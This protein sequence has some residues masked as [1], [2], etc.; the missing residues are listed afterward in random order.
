M[1]KV[2][3]KRGAALLLSGLMVFSIPWVSVNAQGSTEESTGTYEIAAPEEQGDSTSTLNGQTSV[4]G[5]GL[6]EE[7]QAPEG[8]NSTEQTTVF[9]LAVSRQANVAARSG[10]CGTN[11]TWRMD[12][13][14]LYISGSGAMDDYTYGEQGP[15]EEIKDEITSVIVGEGVTAVGAYAFVECPNLTEVSLAS[16]VKELKYAAFGGCSN[17]TTF[18]ATGLQSIGDYVFQ[19]AALEHFTVPASL[20]NISTLASMRAE[21]KEF[22][23]EQGNAVYTAKDGILYTDGGATLFAYPAEKEGENFQ[24]PDGVRTIG[25]G[26]FLYARNLRTIEFPDTVQKFGESAFQ[27]SRLTSVEIP[28]SVTE[29]GDFTFYS[30]LYLDRVRFGSGLKKTSYQMFRECFSL[31][32]VTFDP[33]LQAL[34]AHTFAYCHNLV[35]IELPAYIIEIGSGAFGNCDKLESFTSHGLQIIPYQAFLGCTSLKNVN[36]NE[37]VT[38]I[39][40]VSFIGCDA[41]EQVTMP[42]SVTFVDENAFPTTTEITC[43][44]T[45]MRKFGY[46]GYRYLDD[47]TVSGTERYD[48]AYQVLRLVNEQRQANGLNPLYMDESLLNSAMVRA[49][50]TVILFAH[51]RPD[52]A[53]CFSINDQMTAENIAYGQGS[54]SS[55]MNSWMN[56]DGHRANILS[57]TATS[58][59]IGCF[60]YG[61]RTY[62]VQC[63]GQNNISQNAVQPS[64]RQRTRTVSIAAETFSEAIN[65]YGVIWG[66]LE[67]Y[68]YQFVTRVSGRSDTDIELNRGA[69]AQLYLALVNPGNDASIQVDGDFSWSSS[70]AR[71]VSVTNAGS[72]TA[73][74]AG[75]ASV[76]AATKYYTG[77]PVR[78]SV[79]SE[80]KNL[81]SNG[82]YV[83]KADGTGVTMGM[84][85]SGVA[86]E[87]IEYRWV[88]CDE[89]DQQWFTVQDWT[90]GNEW[91]NWKPPVAGNY[92]Y[93]CYARVAGEETPVVEASIGVPYHVI[94]GVCQMP[95][96]GTGGGFLIGL[97]TYDNPNQSYRYEM[98]IL[99]CTL[100]AQGLPAWTYTTG[101]CV[102]PDNCLWT[103]WQPKYGYYWT[104]FRVY[105]ESG[106]LLDEVCFGFENI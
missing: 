38:Y 62:W 59:G 83:L 39:A 55:V 36:L 16:S 94:K 73:Q 12:N 49:A 44:N 74:A 22:S 29:V 9:R 64:D 56:S 91:L 66:D 88:A 43:K 37:G 61:G 54:P 102:V 21:L 19:E 26:A 85:T 52:G 42:E 3:L 1:R 6:G 27:G 57:D 51:T 31:S 18:S 92:V 2:N 28:D 58:I 24:V 71:A 47:V 60:E 13:G 53:S 77:T 35:E 32:D 104:L 67:E 82:I 84:V 90:K 75:T 105:D 79:E 103:V 63:F 86:K 89:N 5:G 100:Y 48:Y 97:E 30:C 14:V 81:R 96:T 50:E 46:N 17:L 99:D 68:T 40:R 11:L 33:G 69:T 8:Y 101:Q 87:K 15:W 45:Q 10:S 72:V 7:E 23:V 93:V 65:G 98:L 20:T 95:Y 4:T 25:D 106:T 41:L 34:D 76:Q 80:G 78:I 70:N